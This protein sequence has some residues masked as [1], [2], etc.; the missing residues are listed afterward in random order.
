MNIQINKN[1]CNLKLDKVFEIG[2]RTNNS[3]RN[4]L[5]ISKLLGKH[6]I[7]KPNICKATGIL[8]SSLKYKDINNKNLIKY[9]NG[10]DVDIS[11]E[12]NQESNNE[13]KVLVIGFCETATG[14]GMS[15]ASSIKNCTYQTTTRE[16]IL[17]ITNLTFEEEHCHAT[18]HK[19]YSL[20]DK[21][22]NTYDEI[23]LVDDEITT[24]NSMLNLISE[25]QKITNIKKYNI[26]TIL[27]WRNK[28]YLDKYNEYIK[29]NK[30]DI[31]VYSLISGYVKSDDNTVYKDNLN[32]I[33]LNEKINSTNI[34]VLE[35]INI[36]TIDGKIS[37]YKN[38][39]R[40]GVTQK[41]IKLLEDKCKKVAQ[42]IN[43][44]SN[45]KI[46]ILGHGENI[47]IPSRI[48]AYMNADYKTTTRSPI[49]CDGKIIKTKYSFKDRNTTY[50]IYNK[51]EIEKEYDKV[52]LLTETPLNIK[53]LN[54]IEIIN[55]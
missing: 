44:H 7:V 30:I 19:M 54:N 46:L 2:K 24:G 32:V 50:F 41:D 53:L 6:I 45:E 4:F 49:Y 40:F 39:G 51:D 11:K 8:L 9:I 25:L 38:S 29:N 18:T 26:M 43:I 36:D 15:V 47:Y 17:N 21:N 35:K 14:L 5:F 12:L 10:E 33:E 1:N 42:L 37:Y 23:I 22:F 20:M 31:N 16:N 13:N 28:E 52:F 48:A 27:D 34:N 3:K 55:I